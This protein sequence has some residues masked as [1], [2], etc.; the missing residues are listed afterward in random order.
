MFEYDLSEYYGKNMV[1]AGVDE[2]GR[3]PL[4]GPVVACSVIMPNNEFIEGIRDSKKLSEKKRNLFAAEIKE[5]AIAIGI[6][7]V[8]EK[9][10]DKINI[11]QATLL[12]MKIAVENMKDKE[13]NLVK[14]DMIF[15]DAEKIDSEIKQVSIIKGDDKCYPIACASIVAKVCRDSMFKELEEQYP[16]YDLINNKG[17]GTKK[18]REALLELGPTP[19]HRMSFLKKIL[20][21]KR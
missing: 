5:K 4:A 8:N 16:G 10:I 15:I 17:Y 14:P 21:N 11:K 1:L 9:A 3:G 2:V 12:A 13:G 7:V 6:G 18:H 20:G 19:I